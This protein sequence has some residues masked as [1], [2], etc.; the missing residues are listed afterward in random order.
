MTTGIGLSGTGIALKSGGSGIA[1]KAVTFGC[2]LPNF[3]TLGTDTF[4]NI[5]M[6]YN[7]DGSTA[8]EAAFIRAYTGDVLTKISVGVGFTVAGN[9]T[10]GLYSADNIAGPW[11]L[12]SEQ[13]IAV[14]PTGTNIVVEKAVSIALTK[15]KYYFLTATS[16]VAELVQ[17]AYTGG[18]KRWTGGSPLPATLA[19][20]DSS[21]SNF[22]VHLF[23]TV[24]RTYTP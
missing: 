11:T 1:T 23:G 2:I 15:G 5:Y 17:F 14:A 10:I 4:G 7:S 3:A 16:A 9:V 19:D 22:A 24:T 13:T 21:T 8:D 20:V 12:V 18:S 6:Q